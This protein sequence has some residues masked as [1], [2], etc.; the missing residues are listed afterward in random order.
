MCQTLTGSLSKRFPATVVS[1]FESKKD[2]Q[3][4]EGCQTKASLHDTQ[5]INAPHHNDVSG[6]QHAFLKQMAFST[7]ADISKPHFCRFQAV[8]QSAPSPVETM[9]C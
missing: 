6:H 3:I 5:K 1:S 4:L 7:A 2:Q 8:R 9:F